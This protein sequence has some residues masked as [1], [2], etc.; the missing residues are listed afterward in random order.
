MSCSAQRSGPAA[1]VRSTISC[2]VAGVEGAL[3]QIGTLAVAVGAFAAAEIVEGNGFVAAFVA[4]MAFGYVA[5]DHTD[6]AADFTE[7]EGQLL[8]LLTFFFFGALLVGPRIDELTLRVA[9]Y[10]GVESDGDPHDSRRSKPR[11]HAPRGGNHR[12]PRL[13][14]AP[15]SRLDPLRSICRRAGRV[16]GVGNDSL[17]DYLD[18]AGQHRAPRPDGGAIHSPLCSMVAINDARRRGFYAGRPRSRRNALT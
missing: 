6:S 9:A 3:R 18:C 13:V 17:R 8:A 7:D 1:D 11:R 10:A 5:K 2:S 4:G 16:G 15:R 14:R 12:V